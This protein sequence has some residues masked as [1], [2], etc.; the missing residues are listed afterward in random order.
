M[1]LEVLEDPAKNANND[2]VSFLGHSTYIMSSGASQ[3]TGT[4]NPQSMGPSQVPERE[5]ILTA[6]IRSQAMRTDSFLVAS[7]PDT[8]LKSPWAM[9]MSCGGQCKTSVSH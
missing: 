2:V 1:N 3:G 9:G 5:A 4:R 7:E 6:G 8:A